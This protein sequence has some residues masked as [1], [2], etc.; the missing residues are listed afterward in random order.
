MKSISTII[1][2]LGIQ[3]YPIITYGMFWQR[4]RNPNSRSRI[5]PK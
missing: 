5:Q 2:V 1:G 4:R 3:L